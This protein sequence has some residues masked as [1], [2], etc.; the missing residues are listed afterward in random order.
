MLIEFLETDGFHLARKTASKLSSPC[1]WCGGNDRFIVFTDEDRFW[2]R[3][4][5][6]KGDALQYL[7][8]FRRMT[9]PEAAGVVGKSL[10]P[11]TGKSRTSTPRTTTTAPT[12]PAKVQPP[13]W[14]E[15]AAAGI[16][17]AHAALMKKPETLDWLRLKRGITRATAERFRLGWLAEHHFSP[18]SD[19]GL[20]DDGKKLV[21]PAGLLIPWQDKR[22]RVRRSDDEDQK[23]I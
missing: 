19:F 22:I 8:D 23:I 17:R 10:S 7:R 14:R 13:L 15:R 21:I 11:L 3:Q 4:C 5:D 16:E 1:P 2:C 9:F 12:K 18:R 20:P 6:K